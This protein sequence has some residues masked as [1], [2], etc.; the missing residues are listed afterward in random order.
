MSIYCGSVSS[1][2]YVFYPLDYVYWGGHPE[3]DN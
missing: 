2:N 3:E 1:F